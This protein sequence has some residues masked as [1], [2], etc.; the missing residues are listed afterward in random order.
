MRILKQFLCAML[1]SCLWSGILLADT[2]VAEFKKVHGTVDVFHVGERKA[3]PVSVG[4]SLVVGDI[5]R[6]GKRSRAQLKFADGSTLNIGSLSKIEIS[7]FS[8]SADKKVRKTSIRDL[9]GKVRALVTKST[10]KDSFFN[11]K[12]PS[13]VAAVRGTDLGV[14]VRS[15]KKTVVVNYE[16]IVDVYAATLGRLK[17][18]QKVTLFDKQITTVVAGKKPTTPVTASPK[19]LKSMASGTQQVESSDSGGGSTSSSGG[20]SS[21]AG[22]TTSTTTEGAVTTEGTSTTTTTTT[23]DGAGVTTELST[24]TTSTVI[25][26]TTVPT[27]APPVPVVATPPITVTTPAVNTTPVGIVIT[28]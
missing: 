17:E 28:F 3:V 13:A 8:F 7:E 21:G 20:S 2:S 15:P 27:V 23:T 10:D 16:G 26:T 19:A 25:P 6:T 5:V 9:R 4:V 11:I 12:T 14:D 22:S 24:S 1:V 18:S